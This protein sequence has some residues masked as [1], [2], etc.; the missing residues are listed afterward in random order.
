VYGVSPNLCL[1][2][3]NIF[4]LMLHWHVPQAFCIGAIVP[5]LKKNHPSTPHDVGNYRPIT[6][7][8]KL[9][10]LCIIP[11]ENICGARSVRFSEGHW[12]SACR[13]AHS[14]MIFDVL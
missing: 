10:E 6:V 2:L 14:F 12:N 1:H 3:A 11:D 5:V 8:L 13:P 7:L 9:L 4:S